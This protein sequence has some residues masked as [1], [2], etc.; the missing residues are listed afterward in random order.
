MYTVENKWNRYVSNTKKV[1]KNNDLSSKQ[2]RFSF[3]LKLWRISG[4]WLTWGTQP[5]FYVDTDKTRT[6]GRGKGEHYQ[7]LHAKYER[8]V[9]GSFMADV[10]QN[11]NQE[12]YRIV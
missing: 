1:Q 11:R 12:M 2:F 8:F 10:I 7:P 3:K 5:N 9:V 4:E 6:R